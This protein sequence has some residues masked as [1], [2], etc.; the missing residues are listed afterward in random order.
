MVALLLLHCDAYGREADVG[1]AR[2]HT[3]AK[4]VRNAIAN[5]LTQ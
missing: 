4:H 3:R 2:V 5:A 1:V